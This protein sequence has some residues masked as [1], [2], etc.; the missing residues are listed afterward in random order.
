MLAPRLE[1]EGV[2]QVALPLLPVQAEQLIATAQRAPYGRGAETIV[3]TSVRR[4]WQ[5]SPDKVP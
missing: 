3:D 1:V 2:G 4:T 5:I